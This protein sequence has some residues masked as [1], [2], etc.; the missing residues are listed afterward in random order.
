MDANLTPSLGSSLY[1]PPPSSTTPHPCAA[2]GTVSGLFSLFIFE[3]EQKE[4]LEE[5]GLPSVVD[6]E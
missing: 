1:S 5:E 6:F 2:V 4:E 3:E